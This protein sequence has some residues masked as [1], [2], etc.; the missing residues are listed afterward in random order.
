VLRA[1]LGTVGDRQARDLRQP[2]GDQRRQRVVAEMQSLHA[3]GGDRNHVLQRTA[4]LHP[5]D[6]VAGIEPQTAAAEALL[7][8]AGGIALIGGS[9]HRG[10]ESASD[11]RREAWTREDDDG[12]AAARG[13]ADHLRHALQ[14][15]DFDAF[16]RADHG[17]TGR[18][19]RL[20][21]RQQL[22]QRLAWNDHNHQVR[23]PQR[24][25]Q[26]TVH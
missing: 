3:P 10:R 2:P 21:P 25:F 16:G 14:R 11:L 9:E 18:P 4:D 19:E 20:G 1:I 15:I 13:F 12:T 5:G 6:I 26:I 23:I 22:A 7:D 24:G 8:L 17:S